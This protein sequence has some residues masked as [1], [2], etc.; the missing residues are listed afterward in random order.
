MLQTGLTSQILDKLPIVGKD[1]SLAGSFIGKINNEFVQ[2]FTAFLTTNAQGNF[3]QVQNLVD[4]F[5]FE[6]LGPAGLNILGN[7]Y[8]NGPVTVADVICTLDAQHFEIS[9]ELAGTDPLSANLGSGLAGLPIDATGGVSV[10]MGYKVDFGIGVNSS[11][12][13][14]MITNP[15][16]TGKPEVSLNLSAGLTVDHSTNPP[17][18]TTVAINL[19]GLQ[20]SATDI[21]G[22]GNTP[23]TALTAALTL[24]ENPS[25]GSSNHLLLSDI[26]DDPFG[27]SFMP[28]AT[29]SA[30]LALHLDASIDP[31]LPSISTNLEGSIGVSIQLDADNNI[32]VTVLQPTIGFYH[33]ELD[34]GDFLTKYIGPTI[35]KLEQYIGP[36]DPLINFLESDVPGISAM[37]VAAGHGPITVMQLVSLLDPN[38]FTTAEQF[39]NVAETVATIANELGTSDGSFDILFGN[40][41][42]GGANGVDLTQAGWNDLNTPSPAEAESYLPGN[43][44]H[45]GDHPA[46][47]AERRWSVPEFHHHR[48]E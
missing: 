20:F 29:A 42:L 30:T 46:A 17:T 7:P 47:V 31:N 10:S 1:F 26:A 35:A 25:S 13:V 16:K 5:I 44:Q 39:L 12:Q 37:S 23:G 33:I 28:T 8:G 43:G 2:P 45:D 22:P 36:I 6:H 19:F 41:V 14:Y 4:Q 11:G 27:Q 48:P 3:T 40:F 21:L 38:D 18:P 15:F 9:F 24:T 32:D 34:L